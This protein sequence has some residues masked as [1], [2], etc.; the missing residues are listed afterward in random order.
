M[1]TQTQV[2]RL[3]ELAIIQRTELKRLV[4]QLPSLKEH[5]N[6]EVERT[7]EECEP[8]LRSEI[9]QFAL[10]VSGDQNAKLGAELEAK[11]AALASA[12]QDTAQAKFSAVVAER[13]KNA[14]LLKQAEGKIAAA[15]S[16][17]PASVKEIVAGELS[18]FPR[19]D[20]IDQLRKEF[21]EPRGLNPRGKWSG[22]E[23]Y[24]KLDL[25]S[26]NGD[27]FVSNV[28]DNREKPNRASEAWTLNAARGLGGGGGIGSLNE[29]VAPPS[30]GQIL[31]SF[32]GSYVPKTLDGGTGVTITETNDTITIDAAGG[33]G[34]TLTAT[35]YNAE[36]SPI[37]Q[38]QVVYLYQATGNKP[39]VKLASNSSESTSSKTFGVVSDASIAAGATG[40]IMCQGEVS[41]LN[42]GSYT[43]GAAVYLGSTAGSFTA[44]KPSAPN[45]LVYVGI[46]T[47]ANSG[48]GILYVKVQN[49]YEL[50]EIHD[51][52]ITAP[53]LAGSTLLY[54]ATNSLWKNARLTA[55]TNIAITNGDASASIAFSGTLPLTSGGTGA[56]TQSG[57]ANAILPSQSTQNGKY[58]TTDG[59]NVSWGT[60]S[61][62]V[63]WGSVTG[64]LS[65]QTDLQNALNAKA[66][67]SGATFTGTI[68]STLGTLTTSTP[69]LDATQTWNNGS[70]VFTGLKFNVATN[71]ASASGSLLADLQVGGT[72]LFKVDKNGTAT[73]SISGW[74]LP[75][76]ALNNGGIY[77][78]G[79]GT[80]GI[81]LKSG[82][83]RMSVS[84]WGVMVDN[85]HK[86]GWFSSP[87]NAVGDVGFGRVS[88]GLVEI[89]DSV[90]TGNLRDLT[91]RS[92]LPASGTI[93]ADT[94]LIS[95]TQTWNNSGVNFTAFKINVTQGASG[96]GASS[97]LMDLQVGGT[98]KAKIDKNGIYYTSSNQIWI[99]PTQYDCGFYFN[100]SSVAFY[101]AGAVMFTSDP[102]S[103]RAGTNFNSAYSIGFGSPF[104]SLDTRWFQDSA[105]I[106]AQRNGTVANS[107]RLYN[108]YTSATNYERLGLNWATNVAQ[109]YTEKGSGGGTARDLVLGT[110]ATTAIS[111][112][113]TDQ[114]TTFSG[115]T[116]LKAYTVA[117]LPAASSYTYGTAF[118]SDATQAAGTSIGSS[119]TGGGSTK[120]AVY[121]DGTNWLLL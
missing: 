119:P 11:I 22:E 75:A 1:D 68:T 104:S 21:A 89:N 105:G 67:L 88:A 18:R 20:Q 42:L 7:F 90:T 77:D 51:V 59:T 70:T 66:S 45:H 50:D 2:E 6:A 54:D 114:A 91:L 60:I 33:G 63:A 79:G 56:T 58:L 28:N 17:L 109:I 96:S 10:K 32:N 3:I 83:T 37:T 93:T 35:V 115:V 97:N 92:L 103:N 5:L 38:G 98:S 39:S 113:G 101:S 31:G 69:A 117:G 12:L 14:D 44:T 25:V 46:V 52:Q 85:G 13:E 49:G 112:G 118:V 62:G 43:E 36:S 16:A 99:T 82:T 61:T 80:N 29:L 48:N 84:S 65:S 24:Q 120:R 27:S 76:I 40:T 106:I 95:G 64:T 23:T 102:N 116:V 100:G 94:P 107:Y 72:S 121:S 19:A 47:R 53:K 108:T 86:L 4:D 81:M 71:L 34:Q 111:I 41:G 26:Y 110:N 15:A 74:S 87:E 55:G 30:A 9:E 78:T 8:Q 57:A 73:L